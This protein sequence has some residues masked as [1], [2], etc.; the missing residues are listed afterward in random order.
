MP[1]KSFKDNPALAFVSTN[2]LEAEKELA[3]NE[4]T[5]SGTIEK[6]PEGYKI[7]STYVETKSRRI[8]LLLQ[9]S[10]ADAIKDSSKK[11]GISMNQAISEAIKQYLQ[12]E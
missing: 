6:T 10:L 5:A 2:I 12:K 3:E 7:K 8:Q 9:P 1:K 11:N 4:Q